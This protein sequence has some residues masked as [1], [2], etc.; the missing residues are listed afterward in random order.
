MT[1]KNDLDPYDGMTVG[2]EG[3]PLPGLDDGPLERPPGDT[4]DTGDENSLSAEDESYHDDT[5]GCD[6]TADESWD[7]TPGVY[8][9]EEFDEG[10][11]YGL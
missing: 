7:D 11:D 5:L 3:K 10:V 1:N 4:D 8:N 6:P 9:A 2:P